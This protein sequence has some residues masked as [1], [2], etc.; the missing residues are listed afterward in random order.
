MA[1]SRPSRLLLLAGAALLSVPAAL[2][3]AAPAQAHDEVVATSPED[4]ATLTS[5][6]A[7][8][9]LTFSDEV[10]ELGAA[11]VVT[12]AAGA[13]VGDGAPTVD[14]RTVTQALLPD[15]APGTVTVAYR[16]VSGDGHPV[17]GTWTFTLDLAVPPSPD[18]TDAPSSEPASTPA[19]TPAAPPSS[20][21]PVDAAPASSSGVPI[22]LVAG[23][24]VLVVGAGAAVAL[25]LR[26]RG[27]S[28]A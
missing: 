5:V 19:S 22:G 11:V 14:G 4:G 10:E 24:A 7:S 15:A 13:R 2:V 21:A 16:I 27:G 26:R 3:A 18:P 8:V 28:G 12:D 6:P 25:G 23:G 20:P 17:T 9:S 1:P